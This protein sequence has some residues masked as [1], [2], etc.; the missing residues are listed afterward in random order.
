MYPD[1]GVTITKSPDLHVIVGYVLD[2][3][4]DLK[5]SPEPLLIKDYTINNI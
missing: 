3:L 2:L 1:S 5:W 4:G